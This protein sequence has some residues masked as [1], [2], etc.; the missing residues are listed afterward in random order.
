[1]RKNLLVIPVLVL[2][3]LFLTGCA[4]KPGTTSGGQSTEQKKGLFTGKIKDAI[5]RDTPLKCE[6]MSGGNSSVGYIKN[7]KFYGENT[8]K[9][10]KSF[11]II[12]DNCLWG[13]QENKNEGTKICFDQNQTNDIWNSDNS[14]KD[15][16]Q[17]SLAVFS[18]SIFNPPGSVNFMDINDMMKKAGVTI[19]T[20]K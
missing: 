16:Y 15:D 8:T 7:K 6:W 10:G 17:C 13:W 3:S 19:P 4:K 5:L 12:A 9:E 1:M 14:P 2:L 18:D 20:A 11:V